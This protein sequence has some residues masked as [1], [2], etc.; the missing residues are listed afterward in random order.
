MGKDLDVSTPFARWKD[1]IGY[2][3]GVS[4]LSTKGLKFQLYS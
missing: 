2:G 3:D 1:N 4:S